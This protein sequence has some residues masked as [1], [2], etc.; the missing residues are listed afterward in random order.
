MNIEQVWN[1]HRA[2]IRA[3]LRAKISNSDDVDDLLQEV[4]IKAYLNLDSIKSDSSVKYWV[5]QITRNI[6]VDFYRKKNTSIDLTENELWYSE[7]E[8]E[9]QNALINCIEPF[10]KTIPDDIFDMMKAIEI[11]NTP[12]IEYAKSVGVKYSTLKSRVQNNRKRLQSQLIDCCDLIFDSC[13][14]IIECHPRNSNCCANK[15]TDKK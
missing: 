15:L 13:G 5:Y 2:G 7:S 6:I 11:D 12:Q 4:L 9:M 1:E 10:W 3:L 8:A 14:N